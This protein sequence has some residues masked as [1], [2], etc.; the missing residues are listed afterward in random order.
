[1]NPVP[2]IHIANQ[3]SK[4]A[5][6]GKLADIAP[7]LLHLMGLAVPQEMTGRSLAE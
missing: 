6:G 1:M 4:L 7:T 2:L 3:P 5:E